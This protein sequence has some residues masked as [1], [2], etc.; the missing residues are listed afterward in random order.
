MENIYSSQRYPQEGNEQREIPWHLHFSHSPSLQSFPWATLS[1]KPADT[2]TW[3]TA[4]RVPSTE[5]GEGHKI[6]L[7]AAIS[8]MMKLEEIYTAVFGKHLIIFIRVD[9]SLIA[10]FQNISKCT[11]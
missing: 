1:Q 3:E 2:R 7:R 10:L 6:A 8:T 9:D 11:Y 5:A 4:Y